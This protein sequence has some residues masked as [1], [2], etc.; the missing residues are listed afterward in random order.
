MKELTNVELMDINGG[1][2]A[3]GF[4]KVVSGIIFLIGVVDGFVRPLRCHR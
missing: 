4:I 3:W 2:G 1:F